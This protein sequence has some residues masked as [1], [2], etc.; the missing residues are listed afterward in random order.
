MF[1]LWR[2]PWFLVLL[3]LALVLGSFFNVV[4]VRLPQMLRRSWQRDCEDFLRE[5]F[6]KENAKHPLGEFPAD[7]IAL[8]FAKDAAPLNLAL[9]ASHCVHCGHALAACDNVPL[10]S[11]LWLRGRCRYCGEN[12]SALY[13]TVEF[14]AAALAALA[15]WRDGLV[16]PQLFVSLCFLWTLLI[17]AAIDWREQ[18]LPDILTLPLLF[19]GLLAA[20]LG[21]TPLAASDA[22]LGASV[23]Y[24]LLFAVYWL[25]FWLTKREG[26]GFGDMKLLAALGA[27]LGLDALGDVILLAAILGVLIGVAFRLLGK[28]GAFPF[29][30]ALAISGAV[31]WL[32]HGASFWDFFI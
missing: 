4:I 14:L 25:F 27:F 5:S 29:G 17:L 18:L 28:T 1:D 12:I 6:A 20:A 3:L 11:F 10:L 7:K 24:L 2:D 19:G 22:I 30:P 23:A 9:P 26:L 13:P 16:L 32:L 8:C 15:F 31:L 21:W